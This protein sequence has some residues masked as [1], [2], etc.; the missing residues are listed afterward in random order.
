MSGD[1]HPSNRKKNSQSAFQQMIILTSHQMIILNGH[2]ERSLHAVKTDQ[3]SIS[4]H[5]IYDQFFNFSVVFYFFFQVQR[6]RHCR[7]ATD[8]LQIERTTSRIKKIKK[9]NHKRWKWTMNQNA[10]N[11][12]DIS[13]NNWNFKARWFDEI[14]QIFSFSKKCQCRYN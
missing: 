11:Q 3:N 2:F 4:F 6:S 1:F 13:C 8:V 9:K 12:V 5:F 10:R 7:M 14:W